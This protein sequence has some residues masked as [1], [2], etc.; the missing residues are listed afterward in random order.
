MAINPKR[1]EMPTQEPSVRARNFDEVALG[2]TY[3]MA[4]GEAERCL[5]CKNQPCVSGCPVN[6]HIPDFIS[7]IKEGDI[8]GAYLE[9]N[10][11]SSLPAVCGRVCP[12][13][14]QCEKKCTLGVKFEP[15][16]IGRLERFVADW[17]NENAKEAPVA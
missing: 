5:A 11:S 17:H 6:V 2:Y 1:N 15:V 12:Q 7:K 14:N 8:E 9:I 10:K 16:A 13:E 4:K 3:E